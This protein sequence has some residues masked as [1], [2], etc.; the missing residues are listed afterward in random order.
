MLDHSVD[1]N[2]MIASQ[3]VSNPYTFSIIDWLLP[4]RVSRLDANIITASI[5]VSA[6]SLSAIAALVW[7][8]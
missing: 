5:F 4:P 8:I 3:P 6:M 2:E 7:E 1:A